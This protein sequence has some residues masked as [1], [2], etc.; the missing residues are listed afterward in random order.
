MVG[1]ELE[2]RRTTEFHLGSVAPGGYAWIFPK[3]EDIANVGSGV[4]NTVTPKS[5]YEHLLSFV[6]NCKAA[7]NAVLSNST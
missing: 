7:R 3:G 1:V 5:A 4:I 6:K 2:D